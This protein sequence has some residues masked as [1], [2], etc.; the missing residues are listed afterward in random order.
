M[1]RAVNAQ[2]GIENNERR[3]QETEALERAISMLDDIA[4]EVQSDLEGRLGDASH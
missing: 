1:N 3:D 4:D 2:L